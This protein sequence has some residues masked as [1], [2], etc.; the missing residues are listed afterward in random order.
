MISIILQGAV[1]NI[2]ILLDK[3]SV[4]IYKSV[5]VYFAL[6]EFEILKV[7]LY[8]L[9]NGA[10]EGYV[11]FLVCLTS[12]RIEHELDEFTLCIF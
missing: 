1:P 6:P 10:F 2:K 8:L 9:K 12:Q 5:P 7:S 3:C 11:H 4:D